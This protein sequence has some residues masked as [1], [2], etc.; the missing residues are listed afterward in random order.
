MST[1]Q[2]DINVG[3]DSKSDGTYFHR[4]MVKVGIH[5]FRLMVLEKIVIHNNNAKKFFALARPRELWW[6]LHLHTYRQ[7][8]STRG[9][10]GGYNT[11]QIRR[12]RNRKRP[13][14][15]HRRRKLLNRNVVVNDILNDGIDNDRNVVDNVHDVIN[16]EVGV[17]HNVDNE[18]DNAVV[19]ANRVRGYRNY[20]RRVEYINSLMIQGRYNNPVLDTYA[21]KNLHKMSRCIKKLCI[22]IYFDDCRAGQIITQLR[23]AINR[24]FEKRPGKKIGLY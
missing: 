4:Q 24:R 20:F 19:N 22:Y 12:H 3:F 8:R 17:M 21:V 2:E 5:N 13:L 14:F 7:L 16:V 18:I 23:K 10:N 9:R 15:L 11:E 6:I 1:Q